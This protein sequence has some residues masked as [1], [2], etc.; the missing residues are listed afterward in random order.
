M[1]SRPNSRNPQNSP[2]AAEVSE[3]VI[4]TG[5]GYTIPT[6]SFTLIKESSKEEAPL[7]KKG[8][9]NIDLPSYEGLNAEELHNSYLS[10]LSANR[11]LEVNM[12]GLMKKKYEVCFSTSNFVC[13]YPL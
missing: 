13:I 11:E 1:K 8:K 10:R 5:A 12:V 3:D 4:I 2:K 9:N 6:P 7:S